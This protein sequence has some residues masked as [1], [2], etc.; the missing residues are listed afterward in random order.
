[1]ARHD[2]S[3]IVVLES[4]AEWPAWFSEVDTDALE[5]RVLAQY[6][7][8]SI[9]SFAGRVAHDLAELSNEGQCVG[10]AVMACSERADDAVDR[11]R[12]EMARAILGSMQSA[13]GGTL[14]FT[15]SQRKS[16]G[17]RQALSALATDLEHEWED[18]AVHISVRFGQPSRPP[19]VAAYR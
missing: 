12:R 8:E 15:E 10:V 7:G 9:D 5:T 17:A 18:S 4:G 3:K 14:L 11:K 1:M 19:Q 16:G 6:D 2:Q 13:S